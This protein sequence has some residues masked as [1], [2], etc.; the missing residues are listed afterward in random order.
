VFTSGVPY[1]FGESVEHIIGVYDEQH[2]E[3]AAV[4]RRV[5]ALNGCSLVQ[6]LGA[7]RTEF[8]SQE[9]PLS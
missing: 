3:F 2:V 8:G 6:F 5:A 7:D 1:R 4:L 9:P